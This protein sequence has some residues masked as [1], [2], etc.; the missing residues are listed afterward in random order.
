[1]NKCSKRA[2]IF[3]VILVLSIILVFL[4]ALYLSDRFGAGKP[5]SV[6]FGAILLFLPSLFSIYALY[7][8][9]DNQDAI[10]SN[11][12]EIIKK[13]DAINNAASVQHINV[14]QKSEQQKAD[15]AKTNSNV[16]KEKPE[17]KGWSCPKCGRLIN[18]MY[19]ECPVCGAA[20]QYTNSVEPDKPK[21]S[22]HS[23]TPINNATQKWTCPKCK[24]INSMTSISC[25][26]CGHYR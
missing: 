15:N 24:S 19:K 6:F 18:D 17:Y 11:Q 8:I 1:M 22:V 4:I 14:P 9:L 23:K 25:P 5:M 10:I 3:K 16:S 2:T 13:M 21:I 26:E 20:R 12:E 7:C